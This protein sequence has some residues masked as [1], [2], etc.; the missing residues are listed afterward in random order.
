MSPRVSGI[1]P[2]LMTALNDDETIDEAG[3]RAH[4]SR[5]IDAGVDGLFC[6]GTNGE[7]FVMSRAEKLEVIRVVVDEV[8]GRVPV[9]AGVGC[10]GTLETIELARDA[11]AAGVDALSVVTPYFAAASQDELY[12]HYAAV[13]DAV[14]TPVVVYNIPM[15]TGVGISPA[16][17]ERLSRIPGIVGVK[18]SSGNFDTMLQYIERTP[19]DFAVLSG[20]DGLIPWNLLAG[21]HGA[22]TAV[23]N[24]LP[25]T[26]VSIHRE[27]SAGNLAAARAAQDAIRPLRLAQRHGNPNT[28]MKLAANLAGFDLGPCRAPF[29]QVSEEA[30]RE[31]E[32]VLEACRAAGIH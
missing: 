11:A 21:G 9:H 29:N 12:T 31:V 5:L 22:V 26:I 13:A 10:I 19:D 20:N 1:I 23:A 4:T 6:L 25:E 30:V 8:A 15:R 27:W 3:L 7:F 17:I 16:L 32:Q 2:A 28:I 24:V 18:D 14:D